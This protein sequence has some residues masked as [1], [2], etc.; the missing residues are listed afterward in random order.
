[1]LEA[2][3]QC[4]VRNKQICAYDLRHNDLTDDGMEYLIECLCISDHITEVK[5]SEWVTMETMD[6]LLKQLKDNMKA[7]LTRKKGRRRKS[8]SL[9]RPQH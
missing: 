3:A 5:I 6:A 7:S 4:W 1:M 9:I 8:T 2:L